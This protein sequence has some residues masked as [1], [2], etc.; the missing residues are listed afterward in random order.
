M[1]LGF[2]A[3]SSVTLEP[4]GTPEGP[5][6]PPAPPLI[7]EPLRPPIGQQ[8]ES[9]DSV[10]KNPRPPSNPGLKYD[11]FGNVNECGS[12]WLRPG[13]G[14]NNVSES[15][16][17]SSLVKQYNCVKV[18]F[19]TSSFCFPAQEIQAYF[20]CRK[21]TKFSDAYLACRR[22]GFSL[23]SYMESAFLGKDFYPERGDNSLFA[24]ASSIAFRTEPG[25]IH[26]LWSV[27]QS[28]G[29]DPSLAVPFLYRYVVTKNWVETEINYNLNRPTKMNLEY[30]SRLAVS[31]EPIV[32]ISHRLLPQSDDP[33]LTP[34]QPFICTQ[35]LFDDE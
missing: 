29:G 3:C 5:S 26:S 30:A 1:A 13:F 22:E 4:P 21:P 18:V 35:T 9:D 33:F 20:V 14:T 17:G 24:W 11:E 27:L 7:P 19:E 25:D 31:Q 10:E 6:E 23:S 34:E 2:T 28:D 8:S 16:L 12:S 15:E 32:G